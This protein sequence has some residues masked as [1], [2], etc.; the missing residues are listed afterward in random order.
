MFA[1]IVRRGLQAVFV[2]LVVSFL[3]F[4]IKQQVGD[5]VRELTGVSVSASERE[6][7]RDELGLNDPFL[8]Q[9]VRFLKNTVQGNIGRSFFYQKPAM[10]VILD[11]APATLELVFASSVLIIFLSIPIGI[12]CAIAPK[13]FFSRLAIRAS[14]AL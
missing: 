10:D 1:F 12:F 13:N 14:I 4:S 11:K 5:P 8:V 2:M 6:K 3:G 9:Y 7:V